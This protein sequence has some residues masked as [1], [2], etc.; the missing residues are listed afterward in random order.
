MPAVHPSVSRRLLH[1]RAFDVQVFAREDGLFDVEASLTDT[2]TH[3]V[4]L[5]GEARKAGDP[6]HEMRLLLTVDATLT[7]TAATSQTLWMPYA[8]ACDQHGDAYARLVA[9]RVFAYRA[10]DYMRS[11]S[12]EDR[13]YLLY[14]PMVKMKVTTQGE[15]VYTEADMR[16]VARVMSGRTINWT[17]GPTKYDYRF[18]KYWHS[19]DAV[20]ILGGE[21]SPATIR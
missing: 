12:A 17:D 2:K 11:A 3:D 18:E 13:R 1:R 5:A 6:I 20:S 21:T 10:T 9:M 14:N 8:G 19:R 15:Q 7:I 16:G 4:P